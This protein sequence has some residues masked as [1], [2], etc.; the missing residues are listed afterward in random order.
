MPITAQPGNK[1]FSN[2]E[3]TS[4]TPERKKLTKKQMMG[5]G[6]VVLAVLSAIGGGVAVNAL[7]ENRPTT[8]EAPANSGEE[9]KIPAEAESFIAEYGARYEDPISTY[10]ADKD[11]NEFNDTT[12]VIMTD[13]YANTYEIANTKNGETSDLGFYMLQLPLESKISQTNSI[14]VFNNY[15]AKELSLYMNCVSKN[16]SPEAVAVIN[17]QFMSYC[18]GGR[19]NGNT[20]DDRS[21]EGSMKLLETVRSITSK[22]G[23]AANYT[24]AQASSSEGE[25]TTIF[26]KYKPTI[27]I[28]NSDHQSVGFS[29]GGIKLVINIDVYDGKEK[30]SKV[31]VLDNIQLSVWRQQYSGTEP[32]SVTVTDR[33]AI[34][35]N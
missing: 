9:Q 5:M 3:A 18:S 12:G 34:G 29:D 6:A 33:M 2:P 30:I 28:R 4:L 1:N 32:G 22:Y 20:L 19:E 17:D 35:Q 25:D 7:S 15:T 26:N 14:E 27:D 23:S 10:Y 16:P 8:I 21:I 13:S 31:E 11:Y 24:V